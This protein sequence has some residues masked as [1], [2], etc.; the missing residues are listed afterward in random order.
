MKADVTARAGH[1]K[2]RA[3]L[4]LTHR[5]V[6]GLQPEL[7]AF[8]V[9]DARTAGLA[10]RVAPSGLKTW[11]LAFRVRGAGRVRRLALGPFPAVGLDA[12]RRR[13]ADLTMAAQAGRDLVADEKQEAEQAAAR[14]TVAELIDTYVRRRVRGRLRTAFEIEARLKR[15]LSGYLTEAADDIRRRHK[16]VVPRTVHRWLASGKITRLTLSAYQ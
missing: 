6:E 8:S 9:P 10:I 2:T 3:P 7:E 14:V 4:S 12:A 13:A 16:G 5:A 1:G 15:A 11:N